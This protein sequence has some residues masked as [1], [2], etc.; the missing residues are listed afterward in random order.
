MKFLDMPLDM[1]IDEF[2]VFGNLVGIHRCPHYDGG[3]DYPNWVDG[4]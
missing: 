2:K 4:L 3:Y 1:P